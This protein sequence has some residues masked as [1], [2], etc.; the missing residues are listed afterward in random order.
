MDLLTLRK[1]ITHQTFKN[2]HEL[3]ELMIRCTPGTAEQRKQIWQQHMHINDK[4]DHLLQLCIA[5]EDIQQ[6]YEIENKLRL[7][8]LYSWTQFTRHKKPR[9][10]VRLNVLFD[11]SRGIYIIL[12][13]PNLST[14]VLV[15][16][17]N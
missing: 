13:F 1:Y 3:H 14:N 10:S 4:L 15:W 8:I 11:L 17:I 9:R 12:A 7:I 16:C 6:C 5:R 2:P